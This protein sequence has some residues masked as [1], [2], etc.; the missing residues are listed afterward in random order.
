MSLIQV[1]QFFNTRTIIN[2]IRR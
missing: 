2:N 1:S